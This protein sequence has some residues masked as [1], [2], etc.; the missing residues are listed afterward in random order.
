[1][2]IT[3][4]EIRHI[5]LRKGLRGY[6]AAPVERLLA[7]IA[8]DFE[9][10]WRQR[11]DLSDKVEQL[12][13]D[14]Q[15]HRELEGLLRSTLVSAE[16]SAQELKDQARRQADNIVAEAHGEARAVTR[17]AAAERER[18]DREVRRIQSLLRSALEGVDE[19]GTDAREPVGEST[20][21][22]RRLIS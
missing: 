2:A 1:M 20:G 12:E 19:A 16:R 6:R 14:L 7:D 22:I 5:Q 17:R 15:R 10:V 18:L 13:N 21:E 11:A 9:E 4:V 3:P 8:E